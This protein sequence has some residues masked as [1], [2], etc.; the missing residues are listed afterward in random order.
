V[1]SDGGTKSETAEKV[2][3]SPLGAPKNIKKC[4]KIGFLEKRIGNGTAVTF[5]I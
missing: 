4:V 5:G 3:E 1:Q 2:G